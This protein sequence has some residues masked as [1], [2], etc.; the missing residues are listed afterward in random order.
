MKFGCFDKT[1]MEHCVWGRGLYSVSK[2]LHI[3][4]LVYAQKQG[5]TYNKMVTKIDPPTH[6][7]NA[8]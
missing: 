1:L 4:M 8:P 7:R 3:N 5:K 2:Y 6:T